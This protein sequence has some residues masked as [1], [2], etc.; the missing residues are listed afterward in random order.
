MQNMELH[1]LNVVLNDILFSSRQKKIVLS[2]K[3]K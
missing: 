3:I 1:A 2:P